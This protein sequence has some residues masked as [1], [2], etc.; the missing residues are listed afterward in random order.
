MQEPVLSYE[1]RLK[2]ESIATR[3]AQRAP[4]QNAH[5][6]RLHREREARAISREYRATQRDTAKRLKPYEG[7]P[8]GTKRC[9]RCREV[10]PLDLFYVVPSGARKSR[11]KP[12]GIIVTREC[13]LRKRW[14]GKPTQSQEQAMA[15]LK[16]LASRLR[17][18]GDVRITTDEGWDGAMSELQRLWALSGDKTCKGC[19]ESV[20][21]TGMLPPGPANFFPGKCRSCARREFF[22]HSLRVYGRPTAPR[23]LPM[24]DGTSITLAEF[25]RRHRE[26]TA[27]YKR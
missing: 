1:E 10:L 7:V 3:R 23:L 9:S 26:R 8:E 21:P 25:V 6:D 27:L 17:G 14:S 22:A 4:W 12:C 15:Q 19:G 16:Q 24:R 13:K 20:P 5:A 11:C 18:E 2:A